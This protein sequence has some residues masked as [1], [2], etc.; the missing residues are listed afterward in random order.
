MQN[1]SVWFFR[2]RSSSSRL[3]F[4]LAQEATPTASPGDAEVESVVVSATRFDIPLDQ[5]PATRRASFHRK[6]SS[7]NKSNA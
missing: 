3:S 1:R 2:S 6:T 5:S 4:C 7:R